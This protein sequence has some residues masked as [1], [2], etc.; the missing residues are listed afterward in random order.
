MLGLGKNAQANAWVK[1]AQANAW[2]KKNF[3]GNMPKNQRRKNPPHHH[4][5]EVLIL[6]D[7]TWLT[8]VLL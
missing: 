7:R 3:E 6:G 8:C 4:C 5:V 2:V 1:N